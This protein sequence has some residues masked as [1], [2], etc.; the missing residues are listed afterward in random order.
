MV[1]LF[2]ADGNR[3]DRVLTDASG[4]FST[5]AGREVRLAWLDTGAF[6]PQLLAIPPGPQDEP[7]GDEQKYEATAVHDR[8]LAYLSHSSGSTA[9]FSSLNS[10]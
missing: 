5:E 7:A 9:R 8:A 1:V 2:D 3:V 10:K 4:G 6:E